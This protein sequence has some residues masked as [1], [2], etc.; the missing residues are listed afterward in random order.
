MNLFSDLLADIRERRF[1]YA[2]GVP[3][4]LLSGVF[5][6]H[7]VPVATNEFVAYCMA[8]GAQLAGRNPVVFMQDSGLFSAI[9]AMNGISHLYGLFPFVYV[10]KPHGH[11]HTRNNETVDQILDIVLPRDRYLTV[12]DS[13]DY[14]V[15]TRS[16]C[17]PA[18]I[19]RPGQ[20]V[21]TSYRQLISRLRALDDALII[22]S[23]GYL[24]GLVEEQLS[25]RFPVVYLRGGMGGAIPVGVGLAQSTQRR[26]VVLSGDGAAL[27]HY[28]ALSTV[29]DLALDNLEVHVIM[30]GVLE[31]TGGQQNP[32]FPL[33]AIRNVQYLQVSE[34]IPVRTKKG[35]TVYDYPE[36]IRSIRAYCA[37]RRRPARLLA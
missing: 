16:V 7:E 30:N 12:P 1:D 34:P 36:L 15:V 19:A 20:L 17:E 2:V 25:D 23:A 9:P 37:G 21:Q 6:K 35:M 11:S 14:P 5:A 31:S 32:S 3:D 10:T 24:N 4:S 8:I 29:H 27:M 22:T 18:V 28:T 26:I 33:L 13:K